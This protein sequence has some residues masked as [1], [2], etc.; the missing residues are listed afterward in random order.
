M[1]RSFPLVLALASLSFVL[2]C[3]GEDPGPPVYPVQGKVTLDGEV[4]ADATIQFFPEEGPLAVARTDDKGEYTLNAVAGKYKVTVSKVEGE[5]VSE[6]AVAEADGE[7]V[8]ADIADEV[9]DGNDDGTTEVV[10]PVPVIYSSLETTTL[11]VEVKEADANE[12]NLV[13]SSS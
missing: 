3:S 1:Q 8:A 6:V 9:D 12:G 2:G 4:L 7:V 11:T 5:D 13:L 10:S